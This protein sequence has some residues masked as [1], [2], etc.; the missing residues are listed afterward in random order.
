M[1]NRN[2]N[3][4]TKLFDKSFDLSIF[5]QIYNDIK[6]KTNLDIIIKD[7]EPSNLKLINCS[8]MNN[9][10]SVSDNNYIDLY[11]NLPKNPSN[12]KIINNYKS[13]IKIIKD[14]IIEKNYYKN[15]KKKIN[16]YNTFQI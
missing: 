16:D 15:I 6:K 9:T 10:E 3:S 1:K 7:P 14:N 8:F 12:S 11:D 2:I 13:D 4:I 5:N